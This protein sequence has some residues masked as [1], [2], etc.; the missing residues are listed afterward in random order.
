MVNTYHN[1]LHSH[2][3]LC[4]TIDPESGEITITGM[5]VV[6]FKENAGG[7]FYNPEN[8][9]KFDHFFSCKSFT[10]EL[11]IPDEI[12][13]HPVTRIATGAFYRDKYNEDG[14]ES[15]N[16]DIFRPTKLV[17]GDNVREIGAYAFQELF[18]TQEVTFG[19]NVQV[20]G[21]RA[22]DRCGAY[23]SFAIKSWGESLTTIKKRAF[24]ETKPQSFPPLPDTLK[25]I[26]K[27][28][29]RESRLP[30]TII[31][32]PSVETISCTAFHYSS[33]KNIVILS[34][35]TAIQDK[36]MLDEID[37][38][39]PYGFFAYYAW[40]ESCMYCYAGSTAEAF[41]QESCDPYQLIDGDS[42]LWDGEAVEGNALTNCVGMTEAEMRSHLRIDGTSSEIRIDGLQNGKVVNGTTVTLFHTVAQAP[43]KVY[44]V[45][46]VP[47]L[48]GDADGNGTLSL[49]DV[50][51]IVRY[52]A[53]GWNVTVD[54]SNSDVNADGLVNLKDAALLR[55]YLAGWDVTLR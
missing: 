19:K 12:D 38:S 48:S 8:Y 27:E 49:M 45:E 34:N 37:Q 39:Y 23:T 10:G 9:T 5:Q 6:A 21:E 32:P 36:S 15:F 31:I 43:G 17:I 47:R 40:S 50:A 14:V 26:E 22:F 3:Y 7:L 53:G 2:P 11:V 18:L 42:L 33:V 25:V 24:S 35:S 55:R 28:A 29:F 52:L 1:D 46:A 16:S 20:I 30:D 13:G 44:T 51:Q 41:A 4:G 54:V